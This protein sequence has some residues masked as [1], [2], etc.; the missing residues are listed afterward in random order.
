[1]T[2]NNFAEINPKYHLLLE[3]EPKFK[4]LINCCH[5]VS[6]NK[7]YG[8][9]FYLYQDETHRVRQFLSKD[10]FQDFIGISLTDLMLKQ[11]VDLGLLE[12][13]N[14]FTYC[15]PKDFFIFKKFTIIE[16]N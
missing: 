5:W 15:V 12:C 8:N 9:I 2:I 4:N 10:D 6:K 16:E 7:K 1:M 14:N 13:K 11:Y 3:K